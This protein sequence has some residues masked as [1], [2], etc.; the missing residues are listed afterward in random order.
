M[1][2]G[3]VSGKSFFYEKMNVKANQALKSKEEEKSNFPENVKEK[4]E[5]EPSDEAL[6]KRDEPKSGTSVQVN[7]SYGRA[8]TMMRLCQDG[9]VQIDAMLEC[10]LK[11]ISYSESDYVK[12]YVAEGFTLKAKVSIDE[13]M[14]YIEQKNE[15]GSLNAY[16]VNPLK[17]SKDTKNPVEQM[18]VEAWER[19]KDMWNDGMFSEIQE[20]A[21]TEDGEEEQ[22]LQTLAEA[23][24]EFQE[25][26]KKRIK[27]GPPK[28]QIGGSEFSQEEW[29]KLIRKME[30]A[31][32]IY[33]TELRKK[34]QELKEKAAKQIGAGSAT[35]NQSLK[36][37]AEGDSESEKTKGPEVSE[38]EAIEDTKESEV[39][40]AEAIEGTVEY[41]QRGTGFLARISGV[42]KAPYSYLADET[43]TIVY[44]GVHFTCDDKKQQICLGDMSNPNRVLN[45]PL[46]EGGVLRVNQD[47]LGDLVKA[48]DMFSPEDIARILKA[49]AKF[50]KVENMEL[51]IEDMKSKGPAGAAQGASE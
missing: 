36:E 8:S 7:Y 9:R 22:K 51:E 4:T 31:I 33:K 2:P 27:E 29:E 12:A 14:V 18:A 32:D 34:I 42:Q 48:I 16:E 38:T 44:K 17:V 1:S 19:A 28:I 46:S 5:K 35:E 23:L 11:N 39:S 40:E 10:A 26:V 24:E 20:E 43:G 15:D 47:N 49:I 45:I 50:K 3:R 41:A 21:G 30:K 25:Y 37:T 6:A 13:H